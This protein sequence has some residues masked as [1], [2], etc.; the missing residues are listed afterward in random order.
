LPIVS[1]MIR[2]VSYQLRIVYAI[3][4]RC[5]ARENK[6]VTSIMQGNKASVTGKQ[7][8]LFTTVNVKN[9]ILGIY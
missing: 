8:G 7:C 1:L 4:Y 2:A 3:V 5:L 6:P 9:P